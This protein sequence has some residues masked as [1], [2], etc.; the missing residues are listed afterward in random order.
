M[1]GCRTLRAAARR[2]LACARV[3]LQRGF[4]PFTITACLLLSSLASAASVVD[5]SSCA[6]NGTPCPLPLWEPTYNLTESS[7]YYVYFDSGLD[8][9]MWPGDALFNRTGEFWGLL[10]IDWQISHGIWS[11][12]G[13]PNTYDG[14]AT[15]IANCRQ[16]KM[17]GQA[18]RCFIYENL[19]WAFQW[20]E[21]ERALMLDPAKAGYFVP[22]HNALGYSN[23][24]AFLF[25]YGDCV[26]CWRINS[27][28]GDWGT[29][30]P[31]LAA[32]RPRAGSWCYGAEFAW[33]LTTP[34]AFDEVLQLILA[35]VEDGGSFVDGLFTDD[36]LGFP[37][38]FEGI[39]H[40]LNVSGTYDSGDLGALRNAS[41][42][43][44]QRLID[45]LA[46]RGKY[47]WHAFGNGNDVGRNANNNT[48]NG[49]SFDA[50]HCAQWMAARCN[51]D[52]VNQRAITVQM[53][54]GNVNAS[55]AQFLIVRPAFAW[56]GW[57]AG[58]YKA[59][60]VPE[61]MLDVGEPLGTCSQPSPGVFERQWTY[62]LATF[63]CNAYRAGPLPVN[64]SQPRLYR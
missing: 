57:G 35:V 46:V 49:T 5:S 32:I 15:M 53:D 6:I 27:T 58:Q 59:Q 62:G 9:Q 4:L 56:L 11:S 8:P 16:A 1:M 50:S 19:E 47:V 31:D 13:V 55:I 34:E 42:T 14:Q 37:T 36:L 21:S 17:L 30:A 40:V 25:Y 33:N 38:E 61:F 51:T 24:T 41:E 63:D 60:W 29:C 7:V 10:G 54:P 43:L 48:V 52:F 22:W 45:E 39:E 2:P 64:P 18:K 26:P 44:S 28:L 20:H 12:S 3:R 23:G